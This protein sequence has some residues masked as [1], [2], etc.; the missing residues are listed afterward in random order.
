MKNFNDLAERKILA[1]AVCLEE[2]DGVSADFAE[3][4]RKKFPSFAS[5]VALSTSLI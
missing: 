4:R 2:D 1:W 3:D 5:L